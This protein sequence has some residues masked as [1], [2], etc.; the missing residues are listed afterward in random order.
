[1]AAKSLLLTGD[2]VMF[3]TMDGNPT[4]I[5]TPPIPI[6]GSSSSDVLGRIICIEGD[7]KNVILPVYTYMTPTFPIPGIISCKIKQL[8]SSHLSSI[9]TNNGKKILYVS[10]TSFIAEYQVIMKAQQ[11]PPPAGGG[12]QD[13]ISTHTGKGNFIQLIDLR[14][15]EI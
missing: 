1:M 13:P 3:Q 11:P 12:L 6:N 15:E 9:A 4:F 7:E 14:V 8:D 2:L 10:S 5:P